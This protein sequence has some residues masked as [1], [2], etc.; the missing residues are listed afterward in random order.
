M[1]DSISAEAL[2]AP[3]YVGLEVPNH[4]PLSRISSLYIHR[5][6]SLHMM[7]EPHTLNPKLRIIP[8]PEIMP[9]LINGAR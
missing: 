2:H 5:Q 7:L 9:V 6:I 4:S 8:E 3:T 1:K